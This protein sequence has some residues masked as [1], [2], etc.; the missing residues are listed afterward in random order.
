MRGAAA[1]AALAARLTLDWGDATPTS[2]DPTGVGARVRDAARP[3]GSTR[4]GWSRTPRTTASKRVRFGDL[5]WTARTG[6][7]GRLGAESRRQVVAEGPAR[8]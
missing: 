6:T 7:W 2:T 1:A 3:A 5:E 4:T 8:R